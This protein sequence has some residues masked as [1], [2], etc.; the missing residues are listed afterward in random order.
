MRG[1]LREIHARTEDDIMAALALYRP[2][3]LTGGLKDA[4][5][6]R[7]KGEERYGIFIQRSRPY[8][9]KPLG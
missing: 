4:F 1:T 5:V 7:F 2:G 6:R 8:W 3:P 9:M